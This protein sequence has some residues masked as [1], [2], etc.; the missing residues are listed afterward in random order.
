MDDTD[1]KAAARAAEIEA[2]TSIR[3]GA[4]A[5]GFTPPMTL[6][7]IHLGS[8]RLRMVDA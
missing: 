3:V 2:L 8:R 4:I 1:D 6:H 7:A 5:A